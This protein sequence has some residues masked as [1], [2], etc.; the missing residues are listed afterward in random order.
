MNAKQVYQRLIESG[1]QITLE[2]GKVVVTPSEK[3]SESDRIDLQDHGYGISVMLSQTVED[4][5]EMTVHTL[6]G[7]G[8]E[9]TNGDQYPWA[10]YAAYRIKD[11]ATAKILVESDEEIHDGHLAPGRTIAAKRLVG[12]RWEPYWWQPL[13]KIDRGE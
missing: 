7:A 10:T 8:P 11:A 1:F 2:G 4:E 13:P 6:D 3:L 9:E 5:P 12:H